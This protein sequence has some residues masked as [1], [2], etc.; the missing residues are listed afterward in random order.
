[1]KKSLAAVAILLAV[2]FL[3]LVA[4]SLTGQYQLPLW[5][6]HQWVYPTLGQSFK[7]TGGVIDVPTVQGPP[8]PQG[9]QGPTGEA[10]PQGPSGVPTF[11]NND[12]YVLN[13][14]TSTFTLKCANADVFR[15][16]VL[17]SSVAEGGGDYSVSGLSIVF[18]STVVPQATDLVKITYRCSAQ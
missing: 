5:S 1:M 4:Q 3:G 12:V 14:P 17:Q 18:T 16:G 8:G 10:G 13:S 6:N 15:N 11:A 9:A 7:I 2:G